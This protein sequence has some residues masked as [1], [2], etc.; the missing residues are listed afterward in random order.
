M[1]TSVRLPRNYVYGN[2]DEQAFSPKNFEGRLAAK[3]GALLSQDYLNSW[4]WADIDRLERGA[5]SNSI[6]DVCVGHGGSHS[7]SIHI[8]RSG[9]KSVIVGKTMFGRTELICTVYL[10]LV[11]S[12][13]KVRKFG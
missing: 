10:I 7:L 8:N 13:R 2:S 9:N 3:S 5:P 11:N 12:Y 1:K 6:L 4:S